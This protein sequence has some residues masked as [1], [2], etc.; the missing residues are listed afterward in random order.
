[1][2]GSRNPKWNV[3]SPLSYHIPFAGI[4]NQ[5]TDIFA[6]DI[7]L[8]TIDREFY[9]RDGLQKSSGKLKNYNKKMKISLD[10]LIGRQTTDYMLNH[11]AYIN[12]F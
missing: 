12:K 8:S 7:I 5:D 4:R 6:G 2:F 9:Q 11:K 3:N 10:E 1:M